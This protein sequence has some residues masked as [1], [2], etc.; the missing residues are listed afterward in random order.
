MI[1]KEM[2]LKKIL[3]LDEITDLISDVDY[4][5][6]REIIKKYDAIYSYDLEWCTV[7]ANLLYCTEELHE[8]KEV[9]LQKYKKHELNS[10]LNYNLG[11][12]SYYLNSY[13]EMAYYFAK[14]LAFGN[15]KTE[16]VDSIGDFILS[17]CNGQQDFKAEFYRIVT[18]MTQLYNR[19]F[20]IFPEYKIMED[21][22]EKTCDMIGESIVINNKEYLCGLY[23][24]YAQ[25]RLDYTFQE[26]YKDR[27]LYTTEVIPAKNI[28]TFELCCKNKL[29]L[30]VMAKYPSQKINFSINDSNYDMPGL[31]KNRFYY[32][33]FNEGDKV[34]ISSDLEFGMGDAV[35]LESDKKKPKLILNLFIDG[36]PQV[37]VNEFGKKYMPNTYEYFKEGTICTN[38]FANAEWTLPSVPSIFSGTRPTTHRLFHPDHSSDNLY[39]M[40]FFTETL[41]DAEFN[42]GMICGNWRITPTYG[43][44]KGMNRFLHRHNIMEM[45]DSKIVD[46]IIEH[47]EAFKGADNFLWAS[48][49]DL[50]W[51]SDEYELPMSCQVKMP[52]NIR[53]VEKTESKSVNKEYSLKK[54][55]RLKYAM[56]H[57]DRSLGQLYHYLEENYKGQYIVS[58]ISDHGQGYLIPEGKEFLSKERTNITMMFTGKGIPKGECKELIESIDYFPA[59][60]A[61]AGIQDF[62]T[63]EGQVPKW[64]GGSKERSY[65]IS[66]SLFPGKPY[67]IC[68]TDVKHQFFLHTEK[69]CTNDGMI[70]MSNYEVKLIDRCSE[71]EVTADYNLKVEEYTN[72]VIDHIKEYITVI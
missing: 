35:A 66:E 38:A 72:I 39:D 55:E 17:V 33:T 53:A 42:T 50:H 51:V 36:L 32:Y 14:V 65:M 21:G 67:Y 63:Q 56:Q 69:N 54:K 10:D 12:F 49:M 6:A 11:M 37:M 2:L 62:D 4:N 52:F 40:P 61:S 22:E 47:L 71:E 70:D 15:A 24:E 3:L 25:E 64:F 13:D 26:V 16:V 45:T 8:A 27:F 30:P 29:I 7:K 46:E 31:L 19:E 60:L 59:I 44:S 34:I 48:F 28:R 18:R 20:I 57:L 1:S 43:Y 68:L 23:D 5:K 41:H 9:L 58:L